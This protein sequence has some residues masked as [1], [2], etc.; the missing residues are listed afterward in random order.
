MK[1]AQTLKL[2]CLVALLFLTHAYAMGIGWVLRNGEVNEQRAAVKAMK[3]RVASLEEESEFWERNARAAKLSILRNRLRIVE[4]SAYS[5]SKAECDTDPHI[6]ASSQPPRPG[7]V[8][9]SRDLF[10]M[11]WTFG[12]KVYLKGLGPYVINDVM[13]SRHQLRVD[14]F[15]DHKRAAKEFGTRTM[16]AILIMS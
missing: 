8:A 12:K 5:A 13:N 16:E 2:S 11:G 4:V 14:V 3:S 6:A 1:H 10:D 9:V 7:T 15:M